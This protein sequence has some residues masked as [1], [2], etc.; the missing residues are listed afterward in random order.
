MGSCCFL[1]HGWWEPWLSALHNCLQQIPDR[2]DIDYEPGVLPE[3]PV[4]QLLAALSDEQKLAL[5]WFALAELAVWL[6]LPEPQAPVIADAIEQDAKLPLREP[7]KKATRFVVADRVASD[8]I[9]FIEEAKSKV[10][11]PA[12]APPRADTLGQCVI[13]IA[14][15]TRAPDAYWGEWLRRAVPA[16]V[17]HPAADARGFAARTL[18]CTLPVP[19]RWDYAAGLTEE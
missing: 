16:A 10:A 2:G 19:N 4:E 13:A 1:R 7:P 3:Q 14:K 12:L 15:L 5:G 9:S 17:T 18:R 8:L 6:Q 11:D